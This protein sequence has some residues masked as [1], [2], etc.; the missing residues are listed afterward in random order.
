VCSIPAEYQAGA[1]L[2]RV[3]P[4]WMKMGITISG[5][6][7]YPRLLFFIR[8]L[9]SAGSPSFIVG[10]DYAAGVSYLSAEVA[11]SC[12]QNTVGDL[13][14]TLYFH[15]NTGMGFVEVAGVLPAISLGGW[16]VPRLLDWDGDGDLD[17]F[18]G[19]EDGTLFYYRNQGSATN[20]SWTLVTGFFGGIDVGS[21]S[22]PSFGDDDNDGLPDFF[23]AGNL[24]GNLSCYSYNGFSWTPNN[25]FFQGIETNQN[26]APALV[27]LDHDGD[28]NLV[29]GDYD[30][31]LKFYRNDTLP[32]HSIHPWILLSYL[33]KQ[34]K[35]SGT[36]RQREAPHPLS[37]TISIWME[38]MF[39]A[40]AKLIGLLRTW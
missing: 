38:L 20:P 13:S 39:P 34:F 17:L 4:I 18:V 9:C 7:I 12:D 33:E 28:L 11:A 15:S 23:V 30:G 36:H 19:C 3:L 16:T 21:I 31:T 40:Q 22:V 8:N 35:S 25:S 14:G 37:I 29:L 1:F 27:D 5:W 26:A 24:F 10:D 2:S 32:Q 6:A